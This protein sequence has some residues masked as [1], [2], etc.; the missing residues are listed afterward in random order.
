MHVTPLERVTTLFNNYRESLTKGKKREKKVS[1]STRL[2]LMGT[3]PSAD[4]Y[5]VHLSVWWELW[6]RW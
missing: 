5:A 2:C 6:S 3:A 1:R 4:F